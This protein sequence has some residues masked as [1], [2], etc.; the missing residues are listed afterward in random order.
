MVLRET[1]DRL[2]VNSRAAALFPIRPTIFFEPEA[3]RCPV[4]GSGLKVLKT[5]PRELA[6][7]LIG[8]FVAW[9]TKLH[10]PRCALCVGSEELAR[11]VPAGGKFG[12]DVLVYV[13]E[14]FFVRCRNAKEIL[15]ELGE[16]NVHISVSEVTYLARKFVMYL[17]RSAPQGTE[18]NQSVSAPARRLHS[19]L[20]WDLRGGKRASD[21]CGGWDHQDRV[22]EHQDS[23]R[24]LGAANSLSKKH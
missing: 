14:G 23:Y 24:E 3:E 19:S 10:C 22:G 20:R 6:T 5:K 13:G 7:L 15:V 2:M 21:Q 11:L 17:V 16:K 4:C 9:E 8:S 12:Y 1:I 18:K